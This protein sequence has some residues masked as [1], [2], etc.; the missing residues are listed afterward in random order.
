MTN[1]FPWEG[2]YSQPAQTP[3]RL[4]LAQWDGAQEAGCHPS[5]ET[6]SRC[7][8]WT[9]PPSTPPSTSRSWQGTLLEGHQPSPKLQAHRELGPWWSGGR[10]G[11]LKTLGIAGG[12]L[13]IESSTGRKQDKGLGVCPAQSCRR[14]QRTGQAGPAGPHGPSGPTSWGCSQTWTADPEGLSVGTRPSGHAQ[15]RSTLRVHSL[16]SPLLKA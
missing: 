14:F 1:G 16:P 9:G 6:S 15:K 12:W 11:A 3:Q 2:P 4:R 7:V 10:P 13:G 8:T 5:S